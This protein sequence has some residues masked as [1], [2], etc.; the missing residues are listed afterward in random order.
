MPRPKK[1]SRSTSAP[2]TRPTGLV[3]RFFMA[4]QMCGQVISQVGEDVYLVQPFTKDDKSDLGQVLLHVEDMLS[5]RENNFKGFHFYESY[6]EM[7]QK[8]EALAA[9]PP[10][11]PAG[12]PPAKTP[13]AP[14]SAPAATTT[15]TAKAAPAAPPPQPAPPKSIVEMTK[16]DSHKAL[17]TIKALVGKHGI[18]EVRLGK[19]DGKDPVIVVDVQSGSMSEAKVA[20]PEV[21]YGIP[22]Q[23]VSSA[24]SNG[25]DPAKGVEAAPEAKKDETPY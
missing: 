25:T 20:L 10:P 3:G 21:S 24:P 12:P 4:P 17:D 1:T 15:K 23:I 7:K 11:K 22:V 14:A 5:D 6:A 18:K 2:K 16:P 13:P 19:V 9:K 8:V